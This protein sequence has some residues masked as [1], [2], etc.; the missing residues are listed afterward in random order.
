MTATA[1]EKIISP[2]WPEFLPDFDGAWLESKRKRVKQFPQNNLRAS[3]LG[4]PCDRHHY[5][6]IKDWR[7]RELHDEILQSI[8]DE[9]NLHET[10]VLQQLIE[11]GF[12]VVEQQ[13]AFQ[14][15]KPLITGH[16]DAIVNYK[17]HSFPIDVK[18]IAPYDF[19][20]INCIEDLLYS[21]KPHQRNYP[22]QLQLYL[23]MTGNEYGALIF[24][25]KLTGQIKTV[26]CQI[27]YD[28]AEQVLKRA[29]RVYAAL[30]KNE[31]P[32]R[33][34][35]MDLCEKCPF[36]HVCLPDLRLGKGVQLIDD[37]ELEKLLAVREELAASAKNYGDVD[38]KIKE[39]VTAA[40]PGE[41][42][43]GDF[44]IKVTEHTRTMKVPLTWNEEE[45]NY[46]RTQIKKLKGTAA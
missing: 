33:T 5:H 27:D 4:H 14:M 7:M 36:A 20:A 40:G 1:A 31:P 22:A 35:D 39:A 18:S 37:D 46:F 28:Y 44:Y 25:N 43:C 21:R 6:S 41:K 30:A 15:D 23:L 11:M 17:G 32:E 19:D 34:Q 3:S 29:E 8:F 13:R 38:K 2:K 26:W 42:I 10:S 24:K 9:G 45:S 12:E 16:I